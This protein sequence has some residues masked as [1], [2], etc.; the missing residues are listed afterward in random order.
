MLLFSDE[1]F[2]SFKDC[3]QITANT[4]LIGLDLYHE[5]IDWFGVTVPAG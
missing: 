1:C 3:S 2:P 4:D 5:V